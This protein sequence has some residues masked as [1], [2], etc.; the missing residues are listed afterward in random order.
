[1]IIACIVIV[2]L[3][4][5]VSALAVARTRQSEVLARQNGDAMVE[6]V[7]QTSDHMRKIHK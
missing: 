6:Y 5:G 3:S 4:I 7:R 1:M 2:V